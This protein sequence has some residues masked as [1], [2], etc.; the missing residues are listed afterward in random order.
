MD[1]A[2][3]GP[4]AR[5][6]H[7]ENP[8]SI[9]DEHVRRVMKTPGCQSPGNGRHSPKS[10]SPDGFQ[11]VRGGGGGGGGVTTVAPP[12]P[13]PV[14]CKHSFRH[15]AKGDGG[16]VCHHKHVHHVHGGKAREQAESEAARLHGCFPWTAVETGHYGSKN[17]SYADG[18]G[19]VPAEHAP[20]RWV[21]AI[22]KPTKPSASVSLT[23]MFSFLT[24]RSSKFGAQCKRTFKKCGEDARPAD[25]P[26][27]AEEMEKKQKILLW[28]MEGQKELVQHKRSS[29][30]SVLQTAAGLI[31]WKKNKSCSIPSGPITLCCRQG[32]EVLKISVI[33]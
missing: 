7:E 31:P 26:A 20:Y 16:H 10:R 23:S 15:G 8:E 27:P 30:G 17:R 19:G 25:V 6:A 11:A 12:P 14:Q 2:Y 9:L 4:F 5:D 28:L 24:F 29:Y 32:S 21:F 33:Q 3:G 1:V 13:P 22:I 18:I